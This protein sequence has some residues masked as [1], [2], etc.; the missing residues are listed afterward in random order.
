[1]GYMEKMAALNPSHLPILVPEIE[2]LP[3]DICS[4]KIPIKP[5][6]V[7]LEVFASLK[8][9]KSILFLKSKSSEYDAK[10]SKFESDSGKLSKL[11]LQQHLS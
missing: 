9:M 3:Q 10:N 1:M 6:V 7:P 8:S 4:K 2:L 5:T 11:P